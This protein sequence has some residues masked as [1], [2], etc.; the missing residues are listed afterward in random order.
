MVS[1]YPWA[2]G[3]GRAKEQKDKQAVVRE[4]IKTARA[5]LEDEKF[6]KYRELYQRYHAIEM[7]NLLAINEMEPLKYAFKVRQV[8]D[9]LKAYRML[10]STIE[11]EASI[12]IQEE[13]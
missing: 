7:E 3:S 8:V 5:L 6:K 4:M 13:P 9:T 2:L 11:D 10:I 12:Q 1:K